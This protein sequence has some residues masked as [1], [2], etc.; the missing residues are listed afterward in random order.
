MVLYVYIYLMVDSLELLSHD[1]IL[2]PEFLDLFVFFDVHFA[3][4]LLA[5]INRLLNSIIVIF[6]YFGF[7]S[8]RLEYLVFLFKLFETLLLIFFDILEIYNCFLI[9]QGLSICIR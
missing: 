7:I 8:D 3:V 6:K 1:L 5:A 2:H 4:S 9:Y